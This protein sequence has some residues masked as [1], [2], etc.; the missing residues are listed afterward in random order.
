MK[1]P[2]HALTVQMAYRVGVSLLPHVW[3]LSD[4]NSRDDL[5]KS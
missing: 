1:W 5:I 4:L 2:R 3:D